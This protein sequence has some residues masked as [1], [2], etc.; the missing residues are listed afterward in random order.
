MAGEPEA[1]KLTL[2][3]PA[4]TGAAG[5]LRLLPGPQEVTDGDAFVLYEKAV[6]SLP[7]DLDWDRIK[8]WRQVSLA[9]LPLSEI[10]SRCFGR[11]MHLLLEQAAIPNTTGQSTLSFRQL[12][13]VL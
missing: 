7:K 9:E 2:H 4:A 12:A 13:V 8:S 3:A 11:S 10:D 1:K 5:Q 6:K